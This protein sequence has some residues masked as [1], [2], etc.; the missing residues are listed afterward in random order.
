MSFRTICEHIVTAISIIGFVFAFYQWYDAKIDNE[1]LITQIKLSDYR[2]NIEMQ[3]QQA[4][5][6]TALKNMDELKVDN[7]TLRDGNNKLIETL[8]IVQD[9]IKKSNSKGKDQ[10]MSKIGQILKA[11][12]SPAN[13]P[14]TNRPTKDISEPLPNHNQ[15]SSPVQIYPNPAREIN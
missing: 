14:K 7:Q 9:D 15:P 1:K 4:K 12:A 10:I 3:S 6:N 11:T 8:I 2:H 13:N 5:L